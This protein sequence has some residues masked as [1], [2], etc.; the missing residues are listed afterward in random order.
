MDL[1]IKGRKALVCASSKGLGKGCAMALAAEG[2][3]VTLTGRDP[4]ALEATMNEIR[5]ASPNT[6]VTISPGD[7]TTPQGRAD[8]LRVCGEPDILVTNSG[9]QPPGDFRDWKHEDW[10]RALNNHMLTPIDLIKSTVDGMRQ[11]GFGRI[12]NIMSFTVRI[13]DPVLML[14][15]GPRSG[16]ASV[17]SA[18]S[19]TIAKDGVTINNM[20]PGTFLTGRTSQNPLTAHLR[21]NEITGR[22]GTPEE[23]GKICA[24]LCSVH[25]GFVVGQNIL[26]DGGRYRG[27]F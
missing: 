3:N 4:I 23:F 16:L 2:V 9:G 21:S 22:F 11:R 7:I 6:M 14:S 24:F 13:P 18:L 12:I 5:K 17:V 27:N 20:L 8:A 25:A 15:N 10:L 19:R 26:I 1:G